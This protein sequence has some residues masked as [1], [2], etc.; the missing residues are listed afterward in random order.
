M[1]RVETNRPKA[2]AARLTM[3]S[4]PWDDIVLA[5]AGE[6]GF[7]VA[8]IRRPGRTKRV[9]WA[10]HVVV[11]VLMQCGLD[12]TR[13]ALAV[14][15]ERTTAHHAFRTV[16]GYREVYPEIQTETDRILCGVLGINSDSTFTRDQRNG[17]SGAH[18]PT[19]QHLAYATRS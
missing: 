4:R 14:G 9:A 16:E 8:T 5:V 11:W 15:R 3:A 17:Q 12:S 19:A 10:R 18:P 6:Y 7:D 2:L 1:I 13:A